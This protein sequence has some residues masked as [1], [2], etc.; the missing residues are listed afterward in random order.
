MPNTYRRRRRDS[1][2]ELSCVCGVNAPIGSRDPVYNFPCCWAIEVGGY[3]VIVENVINIDQNSRSQT[4]MSSFQT[5]DWMNPSTVVV[6]QLR[7]VFTPTQL[8]SCVASDSAV[9]I[10]L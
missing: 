2:V 1:A 5:V 10:G 7:I 9:C 8:D 6:S 3:D 4:G